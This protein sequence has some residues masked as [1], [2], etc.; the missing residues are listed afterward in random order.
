MRLGLDAGPDTLD[1]AVDLN[2]PGVP[3]SGTDLVKKGVEAT[4]APL[5]ERDL[6]VCQ[7]G[8]F[9]FNPLAESGDN[10]LLPGVIDLAPLTGCRHVTIGPG[11]YHAS[12]FGHYDVRNFQDAAIRTYAEALKPLL[13]RA[14]ANDVL[15]TI[16]AYLKGVIRSAGSFQKLADLVTSDNLRCNLDP[17]SLY[18]GLS[19]VLDPMPLVMRTV[20]GLA[21]RIGLIHV[22]EVGVTEGFHL[23]MGL[24]PISEGHTDWSAFLQAASRHVGGDTWLIVEHCQSSDEARRSV[25]TLRSAA[26]RVGIDL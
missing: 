1:L 3:I 25:A 5:R 12:G 10:A 23:H 24:V 4:L 8:M 16:E 19:D 13:E 15:L 14:A 2:I 22:K 20:D 11:N 18:T 17:S 6:R 21:D 7:I 9:G 26:A